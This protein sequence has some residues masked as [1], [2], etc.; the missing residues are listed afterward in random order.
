MSAEAAADV[1][2]Y[3]RGK[4]E[5]DGNYTDTR[6]VLRKQ[7]GGMQNLVFPF[8]ARLVNMGENRFGERIT[9]RIIDWNVVRSEPQKEKPRT[10]VMLETVLAEAL[11]QHGETIKV[12]GTE[13]VRA[14][15]EGNVRPAFAAAWQAAHPRVKPR[16]VRAAWG[17]ALADSDVTRDVVGGVAYLWQPPTP[18]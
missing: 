14:V 8:E 13:G 7:R 3:L 1:I 4:D 16:G 11:A 18:F 12:N 9:Q 6:L 10:Q 15:R 2:F 17:R 5:G